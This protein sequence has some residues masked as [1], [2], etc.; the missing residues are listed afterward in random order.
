MSTLG[1]RTALLRRALGLTQK[2]FAKA[3]DFSQSN[4]SLLENDGVVPNLGFIINIS[5]AF[6]QINL[7]WWIQ[8]R[9]NI[10]VSGPTTIEDVKDIKDVRQVLKDLN[11]TIAEMKAVSIIG[12][13]RKRSQGS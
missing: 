1:K 13:G 5:T 6:P 3:G 4:L 11:E 2:E 9:G 8:G 10:F 7:N 12:K